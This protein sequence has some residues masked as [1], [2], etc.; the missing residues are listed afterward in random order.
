MN[1]RLEMHIYKFLEIFNY[2]FPN[3]E[4]L[5]RSDKAGDFVFLFHRSKSVDSEHEEAVNELL[6]LF[7]HD[8]GIDNVCFVYAPTQFKDKAKTVF[9]GITGIY[10]TNDFNLNTY[11]YK[12][13]A[14]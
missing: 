2:L 8:Y 7:F 10:K 11:D 9:T 13:T 5:I 1:I 14:A 6:S 12:L 4:V 3:V